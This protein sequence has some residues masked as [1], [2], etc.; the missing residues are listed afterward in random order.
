MFVHWSQAGS[1]LHK[2]ST[3]TFGEQTA[4][5]A[6][7]SQVRL[8]THGGSSNCCNHQQ[9]SSQVCCKSCDPFFAA[10]VS[11]KHDRVKGQTGQVC[12][13]ALL[14]GLANIVPGGGDNRYEYGNPHD[15]AACANLLPRSGEVRRLRNRH[16]VNSTH[17][18][19]MP[20]VKA[21]QQTGAM[22]QHDAAP[23]LNRAIR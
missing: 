15:I 6:Y 21:E 3:N 13:C 18:A 12:S 11:A 5:A 7:S 16:S 2:C 20:A 17:R 8:E 10:E 4:T 19:Q 9:A 14:Q 1:R 22:Q 23:V